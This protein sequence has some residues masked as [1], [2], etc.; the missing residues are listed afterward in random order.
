MSRDVFDL[1]RESAK[2]AY[3]IKLARH[4]QQK[5]EKPAV[6]PAEAS[7]VEKSEHAFSIERCVKTYR[8]PCF[9]GSRRAL[10]ARSA[11]P[12]SQILS[13]QEWFRKPSEKNNIHT[14]KEIHETSDE[15][16]G[17]VAVTLTSSSA[18]KDITGVELNRRR[19]ASCH[20]GEAVVGISSG[21]RRRRRICV[22]PSF[23]QAAL[24]LR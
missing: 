22:P 3:W 20:L 5:N 12:S 11:E 15:G 1:C 7:L 16:S 19:R 24:R 17:A 6:H 10:L 8:Q 2:R 23:D 21:A 18:Q 14:V 9:R 13:Q 4:N